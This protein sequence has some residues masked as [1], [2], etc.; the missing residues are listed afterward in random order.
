MHDKDSLWNSIPFELKCRGEIE[1]FD[2]INEL[3]PIYPIIMYNH[4]Q[5]YTQRL[6]RLYQPFK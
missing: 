3:H 1:C 4:A 6:R 2:K 5:R